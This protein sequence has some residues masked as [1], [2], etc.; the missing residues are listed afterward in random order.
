MSVEAHLRAWDFD[1]ESSAFSFHSSS[2]SESLLNPPWPFRITDLW[3]LPHISSAVS[4]AFVRV[5]ENSLK[6]AKQGNEMSVFP[7]D[8]LNY[9]VSFCPGCVKGSRTFMFLADGK[10]HV[11]T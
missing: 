1:M 7:F 11:E 3:L 6:K 9:P 2:A 5:V 4:S 8:P 10:L